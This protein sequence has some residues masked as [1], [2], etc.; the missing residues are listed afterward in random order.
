MRKAKEK[1]PLFLCLSL[2]GRL[3]QEV[4]AL[5]IFDFTNWFKTCYVSRRRKNWVY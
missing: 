5:N 4:E 3:I 1:H 2:D